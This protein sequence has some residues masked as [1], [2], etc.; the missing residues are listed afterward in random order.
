MTVLEIRVLK[1]RTDDVAEPFTMIKRR[2]AMYKIYE[3]LRDHLQLYHI[4]Y[5][6][7][8]H[9]LHS[10][11]FKV[12]WEYALDR[13][14]LLEDYVRKLNQTELLTR[15]W[16]H[17]MVDGLSLTS[18]PPRKATI[19]KKIT[20]ITDGGIQISGLVLDILMKMEARNPLPFKVNYKDLRALV[21]V[22]VQLMTA[23]QNV[24]VQRYEDLMHW[25]SLSVNSQALLWVST[26]ELV[27]RIE[28][29]EFCNEL[30][31]L[32]DAAEQLRCVWLFLEEHWALYLDKLKLLKV[33]EYDFQDV[34]GV[35]RRAEVYVPS[36]PRLE[37]LVE[38]SFRFKD[39]IK[40]MI[41]P[42]SS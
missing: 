1:L 2:N 32:V 6:E 29:D 9:S 41:V 25:Q 42:K 17:R 19:K 15:R 36:D 5:R 27:K 40:Q 11:L 33:K 26:T 16:V 13:S 28:S 12:A 3:N 37:K 21:L 18:L 30:S 24:G 8:G 38:T 34:S 4:L 39:G 10:L 22:L 7:M 23:L 20:L 14:R 35:M 31:Y